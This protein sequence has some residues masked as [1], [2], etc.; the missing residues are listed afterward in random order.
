MPAA[1]VSIGKNFGKVRGRQQD[2][3][4]TRNGGHA[5]KGVQQ[6]WTR[7]MRGMASRLKLSHPALGQDLNQSRIAQRRQEANQRLAFRRPSGASS[8]DTGRILHQAIRQA[9]QLRLPGHHARPCRLELGVR[10]GR[11]RARPALDQDRVLLFE[12]QVDG[13]GHQSHPRFPVRL[14]VKDGKLH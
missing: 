9:Q 6:L 5:R 12:Q 8:T 14:F 13:V 10:D 1:V 2:G 4:I 11:G 3:A 7:E